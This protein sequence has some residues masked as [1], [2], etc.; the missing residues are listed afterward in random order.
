VARIF[1]NKT[2]SAFFSTMQ[3]RKKIV[4]HMFDL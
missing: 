4:D 3:D 2:P 1:M